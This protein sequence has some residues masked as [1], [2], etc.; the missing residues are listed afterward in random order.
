MN[1]KDY[2]FITN[3]CY[4]FNRDGQVLLQRKARGFGQGK[5]NGPGGKKEKGESIEDSVK[6]EVLEETCLEILNPRIRGELGFVFPDKKDSF[7]SYVFVVTEFQ[8]EPKDTG[9][10]VLK[11]FDLDNI[12]L[13]EMWDDDRYWL[14]RVLGGEYL[15]MKFYFDKEGRVDKYKEIQLS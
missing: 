1:P 14:K 4:V 12:P 6:R 7:F 9:E 15:K 2:D 11:W 5:W 8:G 10:G 3:I 13:E